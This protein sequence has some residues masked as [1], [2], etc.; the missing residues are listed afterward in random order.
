MLSHN[1]KSND[2][3]QPLK[4]VPHLILYALYQ[5][6]LSVL[7]L[8]Y[9]ILDPGKR[10]EHCMHYMRSLF[11][12]CHKKSILAFL[13]PLVAKMT[14]LRST[15]GSPLLINGDQWSWHIFAGWLQVC[16]SSRAPHCK[17]SFFLS[18]GNRHFCT[19]EWQWYSSGFEKQ[20]YKSLSGYL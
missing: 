1:C 3:V 18:V 4:K 9:N 10:S 5:N 16:F 8:L 19:D 13:R 20:W 15:W 17:Q 14:F 6:L 11:I 7:G 12:C 2:S